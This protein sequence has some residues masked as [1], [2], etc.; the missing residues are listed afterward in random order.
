[1]LTSSSRVRSS[2]SQTPTWTARRGRRDQA[3]GQAFVGE[4]V[5]GRRAGSGTGA[6][7]TGSRSM[8][9]SRTD[10]SGV[11]AAAVLAA[12]GHDAAARQQ[13]R[14]P[15]RVGRAGRAGPGLGPPL[16]VARR[17]P[18]LP[19]RDR[20]AAGLARGQQHRVLPDVGVESLLAVV[21]GPGCR[22]ARAPTRRASSSAA[23]PAR[24]RCARPARRGSRQADRSPDRGPGTASSAEASPR[25]W[26]SRSL[27]GMPY[28]RAGG[29]ARRT[30]TR[31]GRAAGAAATAGAGVTPARARTAGAA[32]SA[33][34]S[35][36]SAACA[37]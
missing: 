30:A 8:A 20:A 36:R 27:A 19:A 23:R 26:R 2:R 17:H 37:G 12:A 35:P 21:R 1:M 14:A 16:L 18:G 29:P 9:A 4:P 15:V 24:C 6:A 5:H 25:L 10:I 22:R 11:Q 31:R 3:G 33:R 32:R 28:R 7:G 13:A 34:R